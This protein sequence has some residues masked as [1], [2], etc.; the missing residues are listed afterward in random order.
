MSRA[1]L[2]VQTLEGRDLPTTFTAGYLGVHAGRATPHSSSGPTGYT[3]AQV[4]H[5]Y[6]FDQI[7]FGGVAGDGTGQTIAIVDAY[8]DPTIAGDVAQFDRA[9]GLPDPVFQK[10]NQ[11][12]GST[13]PAAS[14]TWGVEIALDVEWA[15]AIAPAARILLVEANSNS[16]ADLFAAVIY[17]A[18]QSG[19]SVL[20]MSWGTP[21]FPTEAASDG[22][23]TTP[24]GHSGVTFL[25]APGDNGAPASYPSASPNVIAVGGTTLTLGSG[26]SWANESGWAGGAGGPSAYEPQPLEQLGQVPQTA[27]SRTSPDVAYD[28]DPAT[29]FPIY[30]S[31]N[32][33]A[34]AAWAQFGGT[35]AGTP[36]WAALIAIADQGRARMGL[37]SLDGPG[38]TLPALYQLPA[39]DFHDIT[40]GASAGAPRYAA[41]PGY[42][43]VAGRG[44]PVA[45]LVVR[46]L[47]SYAGTAAA[48]PWANLSGTAS[49]LVSARNADGSQQVFA[50]GTDSAL[51]VRT[52]ATNGGWGNWTSLG[53]SA[54]GLT[55]ATNAAG[56]QDVF[57]LG[58]GSVWTRSETSS[59][60]WTAWA[61]LGGAVKSLAAGRDANGTEELFAVGTDNAV[62]TRRQT[63]PGVW[64]AWASLG[65]V[66][67]SPVVLPNRQGLLDLFVIGGD[68][69]VWVRS[70][71][72]VGVWT[73]WASLSGAVKSL[74]A[75]RDANGT[76]ELFAVGA[77]SALWTRSETAPG[78]WTAW[79]SLGGVASGLTATTNAAGWQ[80]L[81]VIGTDGAAWTR[82]E[83]ATSQWAPWTSLGGLAR[84]LAA[85]L[86]SFGRP[87]VIAQGP[88]GAL[89]WKDQNSGGMWV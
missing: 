15:H 7:K 77:D 28:A 83:T 9:F 76:E 89:W 38:Q 58:L 8:D 2:D 81:F 56:W 6:G 64:T 24:A 50:V 71:T 44:T 74:A 3:P 30:D 53:G 4:R 70:E 47:V 27:A 60:V 41:G 29:G 49:A 54:T 42:D 62:W 75:G 63:A 80:D 69:A 88:I 31:Y 85:G 61:S 36:Q 10:V 40:T 73:A 52:Q 16:N 79:A 46:D 72:A 45:N 18:R 87:E 55:V 68:K 13:P 17:A 21:E 20:S 65:G 59:G 48:A 51:W 43:L 23:F 32:Y 35:S 84:S 86:D 34:A 33:P 1:R 14:P 66:V 37:G 82:S 67:Q 25:A 11:A 12:G 57:V 5:A 78:T 19:V 39:G 26:G 22:V